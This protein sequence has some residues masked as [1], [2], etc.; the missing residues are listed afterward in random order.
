MQ[1]H[2]DLPPGTGPACL[3]GQ[4]FTGRQ[5]REREVGE[6]SLSVLCPQGH[7][8]LVHT[9]GGARICPPR[10]PCLKLDPSSQGHWQPAPWGVAYTAN[11]SCWDTEGEPKPGGPGQ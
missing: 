9:Y 2:L 11:S 5:E 7:L 1:G 8:F 6:Q 4:P 3:P 10:A